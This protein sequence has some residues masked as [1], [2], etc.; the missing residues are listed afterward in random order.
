MSSKLSG[1]QKLT[2]FYCSGL[3]ALPD[4]IGLLTGLLGFHLDMTPMKEIPASIEAL[5]ALRCLTV[6][7]CGDG[8]NAYKTLARC[9]PSMRLLESLSLGT[10]T[11][12]DGLAIARCLRAWP[13]PHLRRP[14]YEFSVDGRTV[15]PRLQRHW[16]VLGLP[17]EAD[18]WDDI[19]IVE[20][21]REQQSKV[22]A[23]A[24]GLHGRLGARSMVSQLDEQLLVL[25]ADEVLG[26]WSLMREWQEEEGADQKPTAQEP[27]GSCA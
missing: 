21:F 6:D 12:E 8:S 15:E 22:V 16:R 23:F 2:V 13:P 4:S 9:L 17:A 27:C 3:E 24:S 10:E 18:E 19:E 5:T 1:L 26:G 14:I 11:E 25:V 7:E 20:H